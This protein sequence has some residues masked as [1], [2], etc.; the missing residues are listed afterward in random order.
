[1]LF[2]TLEIRKE[3]PRESV[4]D[5]NDEEQLA[6][7]RVGRRRRPTKFQIFTGPGRKWVP[8][9]NFIQLTANGPYMG[10]INFD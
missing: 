1:M 5:L 7:F 4:A 2:D 3:D 9:L 6:L 8:F 10:H